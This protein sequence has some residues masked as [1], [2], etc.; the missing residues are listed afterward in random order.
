[1]TNLRFGWTWDADARNWRLSTTDM[2]DE[3]VAGYD[4]MAG[5]YERQLIEEIE[6]LRGQSPENE[7]LE[8]AFHAEP[9]RSIVDNALRQIASPD[10]PR[11]SLKE[12][13]Q[14][15]LDSTD[16]VIAQGTTSDYELA[17]A[18]FDLAYSALNQS[19]EPSAKPECNHH[20]ESSA[21]ETATMSGRLC[22]NCGSNFDINHKPMPDDLP[23]LR[24][25]DG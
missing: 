6:R 25:N 24:T 10:E 16:N 5:Y 18:I 21:W 7:A 8:Q 3:L 13:L 11:G 17:Q 12:A 20:E 22:H 1:M 15:I 14:K 19:A 4:H 9:Q 2:G 23:A